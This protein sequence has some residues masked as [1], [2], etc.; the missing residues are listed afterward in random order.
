MTR[1]SLQAVILL[2]TALTAGR[3]SA[4]P[5]CA[6]SGSTP[7]R[8]WSALHIQNADLAPGAALFGTD[9]GRIAVLREYGPTASSDPAKGAPWHKRADWSKHT[10]SPVLMPPTAIVYM[11]TDGQ[12][13]QWLCGIEKRGFT[14]AYRKRNTQAGKIT[15]A[16]IEDVF[17][18]ERVQLGRQAL[19]FT[20]SKD[21]RRPLLP[22]A[23]INST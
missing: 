15:P 21:G 2:V 4:V 20:T 1:C 8:A 12:G 9:G 18:T 23:K 19:R 5:L 16:I 13:K 10:V 14:E 17:V 11:D 22:H 6:T 7:P 3:A